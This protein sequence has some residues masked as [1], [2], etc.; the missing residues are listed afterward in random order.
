MYN[1]AMNNKRITATIVLIFACL[2]WGS[3]FFVTK[4]SLNGVA[5]LTFLT[6]RFLIATGATAIIALF[7][8]KK[9]FDDWP[10]GSALG[11]ILWLCY[12]TQT[13]GLQ[14]TT[15]S[16]SGFITGLFVVFVP[17]IAFILNSR[18]PKYLDIVAV[19]LSLVGLYILTGGHDGINKGDLITIFAALTQAIYILVVGKYSKDSIDPIRALFQ[20]FFVMTILSFLAAVLLDAPL[21]ISNNSVWSALIYLAIFPSTVAFLIQLYSQKLVPA[22]QTSMILTSIA[23]FAAMLSWLFHKEPITVHGVMGGLLMLIAMV[24]SQ[25]K[26][27]AYQQE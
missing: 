18:I 4:D 9:L 19:V 15:P 16:N 7:L 23:L 8:K 25:W 12:L 21:S 3:S 6:F 5:P 17:L 20:Q 14:Y 26:N 24:M 11:V 27:H 2:I 13:I 1:I 22:F 10:I